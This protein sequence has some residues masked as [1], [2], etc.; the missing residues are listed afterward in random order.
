MIN[1]SNSILKGFSTPE[2]KKGENTVTVTIECSSSGA[3]QLEC[4]IRELHMRGHIGHS[5]TVVVDDE[6]EDKGGKVGWDG[7]GSDRIL[8]F[9]GQDISELIKKHNK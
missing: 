8:K 3:Y 2:L 1:K 7:D 4:L 9:N 6:A 5:F